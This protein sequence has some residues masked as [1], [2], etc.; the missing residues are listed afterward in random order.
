MFVLENEILRVTVKLKGAELDSIHNK[1]NK[2]DYLW[3]GDPAVWGKKSP[4]LF[5]IV[6][7]L[8]N[9]T[10]FFMDK[11]LN[12]TRHGFARDTEF[13]VADESAEILELE[14]ESTE[15]TMFQFPFH[16]RFEVIYRL[17][18]DKLS[19]TYAVH[20]TGDVPMPFSV[21]GHP[22][23]RLPLQDGSVY[24]DYY[25]QFSETENVARWPIAEGGL[26]SDTPVPMLRNTDR[27]PL[28]KELFHKDAIV[29]KKLQSDKVILKCDTS[30][31]GLEM[32]ITQFP[33]LGVWAAKDADFVC[34]E[35]WRGLADNI[36]SDQQLL[37]KEGIIILM[38]S[39]SFECTWSVTVF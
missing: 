10:A 1:K 5:P 12:M 3:S 37:D 19:V 35:P 4:V 28:S 33:Y 26:I 8:K 31:A 17:K 22:A 13:L 18:A 39:N 2:V 14:I 15:E 38:P 29:F 25:L 9:D 36:N 32:D 24:S 16:F 27:L 11:T 7:T 34:I 20:N 21:G 30:S 6:G 23:F